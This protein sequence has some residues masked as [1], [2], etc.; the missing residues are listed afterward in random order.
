[1]MRTTKYGHAKRLK[2]RGWA[3]I[4]VFGNIILYELQNA[5]NTILKS[6]QKLWEETNGESMR[7]ALHVLNIGRLI[8]SLHNML[9]SGIILL[10]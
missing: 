1:M 9:V 5:F 10:Q 7:Y 3:R 8:S 6:T 4:G 2:S